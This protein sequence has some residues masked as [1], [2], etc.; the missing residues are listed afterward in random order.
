MYAIEN[1]LQ[2]VNERKLIWFVFNRLRYLLWVFQLKINRPVNLANCVETRFPLNNVKVIWERAPQINV[3]SKKMWNYHTHSVYATQTRRI[4]VLMTTSHYPH[5]QHNDLYKT[6]FVLSSVSLFHLFTKDLFSLV[7]FM[8][9]KEVVPRTTQLN[10]I[11]AHNKIYSTCQEMQ[12][13]T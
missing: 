6:C 1:L 4:S 13:D 3:N 2:Y 7:I 10:Q 12:Y 11:N 5:Q 8:K 9:K